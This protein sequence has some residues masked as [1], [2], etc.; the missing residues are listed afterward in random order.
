[1]MPS[2]RF[3][4]WGIWAYLILLVFE[5]ALRKWVLPGAAD[6]LLIIR[7][8]VVLGVYALVLVE[9]RF[10]RNGFISFTIALALASGVFAF[11]G[12]HANILVTAYG[13]RTNYLHLP[14]IWVMADYLDRR[15]ARRMGYAIVAL[16]IPMTILMVMQ[17][18]SGADAWVNRGV[19]GGEGGGIHGAMGRI[20]P[21]GFFSFITGPMVFF[22]VA[23][24]FL[25][26]FVIEK[27]K[28]WTWLFL[29]TAG[30][31]V[32]L[33]L[34]ISISRGVMVICAFVFA[35]FLACIILKGAF[36]AAFARALVGCLLVLVVLRFMPVT[37]EA[38]TVFMDRWDTAAAESQGDAWGSLTS[39]ISAGFTAPFD[40]M[41]DVPFFG[42]GIGLGSNV[43]SKLI[44]GQMGF[45][46]AED[47]WSR[48]MMELGPLLGLGFIGLRVAL[49]AY[50]LRLSWRALRQRGDFLPMLVTTAS[51]PPLV[52]QQ[53]SQATQLGFA[54]F[55]AG[56]ALALINHPELPE[57]DDDQE[58][59][60]EDSD[61]EDDES[62][63]N[64]SDPHDPDDDTPAE[65]TEDEKRRRRLRGLA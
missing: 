28:L 41:L 53:W 29:I 6:I 12:G 13:I 44:S 22:P 3:I 36:T 18:R 37:S 4:K 30:L 10:P 57:S 61:D 19:G 51:F 48:A 58:T 42:Q 26:S 62:A 59:S 9:G 1:M 50:L 38:W 5:G 64:D 20:R 49:W 24:A 54:I 21:P 7:D 2:T 40:L 15:D 27:N 63:D 8:P 14:F 47:E 52:L 60:D 16:A 65:P 55:D 33:A 17:N 56:L 45:L 31:C 39:R 35:A 43:A 34:P 23:T 32:A 25:L 11:I 46:L